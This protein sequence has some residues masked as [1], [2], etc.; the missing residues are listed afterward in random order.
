MPTSA[1]L[2]KA[3]QFIHATPELTFKQGRMLAD[4]AG[5]TFEEL[6]TALC[7]SLRQAAN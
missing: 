7:A 3:V 1:R 4:I 6:V 2:E 5:V